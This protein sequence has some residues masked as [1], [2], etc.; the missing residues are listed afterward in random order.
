MSSIKSPRNRHKS[1]AI[2]GDLLFASVVWFVTKLSDP[3]EKE[4]AKLDKPVARRIFHFLRE[5]LAT[6]D[7]PRSIGEAL[8]TAQ[9]QSDGSA[10][11][12]NL[13]LGNPHPEQIASLPLRARMWISRIHWAALHL[14]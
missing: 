10:M 12:H 6:F 1:L 11:S 2:C 9:T 8:T 3:A 14:T 4:R 5:R 13:G 7:D